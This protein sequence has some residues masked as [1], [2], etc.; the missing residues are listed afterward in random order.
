MMPG[1]WSS[2]KCRGGTQEETPVPERGQD[3]KEGFPWFFRERNLGIRQ[4][5]NSSRFDPHVVGNVVVL[6]SPPFGMNDPEC[7]L[8]KEFTSSLAFGTDSI[9]SYLAALHPAS[10]PVSIQSY[11]ICGVWIYQYF[12]HVGSLLFKSHTLSRSNVPIKKRHQCTNAPALQGPLQPPSACPGS[13][14]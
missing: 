5:R 1:R 6:P 4:N 12:E 10:G 11:D 2:E 13:C 9:Q 8:K 14:Q 3:V 7:P